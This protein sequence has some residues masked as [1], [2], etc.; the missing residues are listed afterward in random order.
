MSLALLLVN[1]RPELSCEVVWSNQCK[2][3]EDLAT[4]NDDDEMGDITD[5]YIAWQCIGKHIN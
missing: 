3:G 5:W 1:D 4:F 2:R